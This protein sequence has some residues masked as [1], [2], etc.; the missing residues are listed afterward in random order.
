MASTIAESIKRAKLL[1]AS[2]KV[3]ISEALSKA[4]EAKFAEI[5]TSKLKTW[6]E[7]KGIR[8]GLVFNYPEKELKLSKAIQKLVPM[9]CNP[10]TFANAFEVE[11]EWKDLSDDLHE[12]PNLILTICNF[13]LKRTDALTEVKIESYVGWSTSRFTLRNT[14][15]QSSDYILNKLQAN[16]KSVEKFQAK[17][18]AQKEKEELALRTPAK[19][20]AKLVRQVLTIIKR[21]GL[22]DD[23]LE[24]VGNDD[25]GEYVY[26]PDGEVGWFNTG[27]ARVAFKGIHPSSV[28]AAI[29]IY[30]KFMNRPDKLDDKSLNALIKW[31]EE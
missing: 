10:T 25:D 6:K 18:A 16:Q 22:D 24:M 17:V 31:V 4:D 7:A 19:P 23:D 21:Q 9:K 12:V 3:E 20:T 8:L 27:T 13:I 15:S 28:R 30:Y 14:Y 26:G 11:I 5:V 1:A 2:D 29:D